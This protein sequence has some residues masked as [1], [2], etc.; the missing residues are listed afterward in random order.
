M[1]IVISGASGLIGVPLVAALRSANHQV[2][3]LVRRPT[4]DPQEVQWDPAA[5]LLAPTALAG[6]DAVINLAGA[7]I[8][9]KRWTPDYKKLVLDSRVSSTAL[10]AQTI[11]GMEPK[12]T[13]FLS[14]SAIGYYG[15]TG[16]RSVDE[17]AT[18]G[19]GF[20]ADV[21]VRWEEAAAPAATAGV[22]TV[23]L[24]T[25]LVMTAS[26]GLLGRQ[27]LPA[28]LG[29]GGRLG[30][31]RQY[32]SWITLDDEVAAIS[33]LL[34][35]DVSGPVN[36]TSPNPVTQKDFAKTL[37]SVLKRPAFSRLPGAALSLALGDFAAE[38]VLAGQRV[39]PAKLIGAGFPFRS[40]KLEDGLRSVLR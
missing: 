25:G 16:D 36:L 5:G 7:G 20:L 33:Y 22:R 12:P 38:G 27:L 39:L 9:D 17:T 14:G 24:R 26:G 19:Q 31:G 1:K 13:V 10:L 15:D 6:A 34:T 11:A 40:T 30:S 23:L 18:H 21:C 4:A 3:T 28:K 2:T 29:L 37:G 35:A 8:A 32:Q